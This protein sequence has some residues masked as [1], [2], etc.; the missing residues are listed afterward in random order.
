MK[1]TPKTVAITA[2]VVVIGAWYLK[3]QAGAA[4]ASAGEAVN[5]V[6][7]DNVFNRGAESLYTAITGSEDSPGADL[8]DWVHGSERWWN[9]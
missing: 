8:A 1:W 6:N 7:R 2:G 3:S 9:D 4:L 5:P